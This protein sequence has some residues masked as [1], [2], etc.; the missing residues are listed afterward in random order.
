[1]RNVS[2]KAVQ[3]TPGQVQA[4]LV[5]PVV[6]P[7]GMPNGVSNLVK[8]S[9]SAA[10]S[11]GSRLC[12]RIGATETAKMRRKRARGTFDHNIFA[13]N[14]YECKQTH[15]RCEV[16]SLNSFLALPHPHRNRKLGILVD[17]KRKDNK[18]LPQHDRIAAKMYISQS[19]CL[20]SQFLPLFAPNITF[21]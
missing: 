2:F 6:Q 17:S 14:I 21:H 5:S 7:V 18:I 16:V 4:T 11:S 20:Q 12:A 15:V 10:L 13:P 3:E 1:V 19:L 9:A 8:N